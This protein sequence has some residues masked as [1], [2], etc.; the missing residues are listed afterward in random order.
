MRESVSA[1]RL[2]SRLR[3]SSTFL[4]T[5]LPLRL[6]R[7][8]VAT[9]NVETAGQ[10]AGFEPC[11]TATT[12]RVAI[13]AS[14]PRPLDVR[15]AIHVAQA[16]VEPTDHRAE[17]ELA[18]QVVVLHLEFDEAGHDQVDV[19]LAPDPSVDTQNRQLID[20]SKPAIN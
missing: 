8:I 2:R 20:T 14:F 7:G 11:P 18:H 9:V 3:P 10:L 4:R 17:L 15:C 6:E 12:T 13:I 19:G 16:T 5:F 1:R